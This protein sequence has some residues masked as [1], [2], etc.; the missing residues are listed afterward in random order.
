M[1]YLVLV[2]ILIVK[3]FQWKEAAGPFKW[4]DC[5]FKSCL[6]LYFTFLKIFDNVIPVSFAVPPNI[7]GEELNATVMLGGPVMLHCQGDAIPPPTLSWR[8]D[9]RP[10]FGKPGL[11][12][13]TDGSVLKVGLDT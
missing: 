9:G 10:L 12:V 6:G 7:K 13:S 4:K 2:I 1:F 11:T 8:K 3:S 5:I